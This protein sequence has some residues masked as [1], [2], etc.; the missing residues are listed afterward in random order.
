MLL[1]AKCIHLIYLV[2]LH[3]RVVIC[4]TQLWLWLVVKEAAHCGLTV[5]MPTMDCSTLET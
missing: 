5:F 4:V 2:E 1:L 3:V